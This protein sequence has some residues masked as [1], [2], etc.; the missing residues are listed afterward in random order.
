MRLDMMG[1]VPV[2]QYVTNTRTDHLTTTLLGSGNKF[3]LSEVL[4]K[5]NLEAEKKFLRVEAKLNRDT[6]KRQSDKKI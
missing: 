6:A 5:R 2:L 3:S 1:S 4:E